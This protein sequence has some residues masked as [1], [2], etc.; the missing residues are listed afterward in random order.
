MLTITPALGLLCLLFG[1]TSTFAAPTARI[2]ERSFNPRQKWQSDEVNCVQILN[3]APG[4]S[5]SPGYFVRMAYG[6]EQCKGATAAGPWTIH[7]YNNPDI[8]GGSLRYDYH[9]VLADG[10]NESETQYTWN[11]PVDQYMKAKTVEKTNDY[12]VRIETKSREGVKLVGNVGPF[13][14]NPQQFQRRDDLAL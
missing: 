3:P 9:E 12:Y 14:I 10:I 2:T 5:Y 7:L 6:T 8:Q 13:A 1:S 4:A 11:I